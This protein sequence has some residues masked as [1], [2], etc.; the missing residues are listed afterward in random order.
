MTGAPVP[1]RTERV[2]MVEQAVEQEGLIR[3]EKPSAANNI[4]QKS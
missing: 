2:I 1:S 4:L 3:F